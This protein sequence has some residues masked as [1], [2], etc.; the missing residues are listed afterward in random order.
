MIILDT[1]VISE[2][3]KSNSDAR[4][5]TWLDAQVADTLH[6]TTIN[7]AELLVGIETL[8]DGKRK[9]GLG[10]ALTS[11]LTNLFKD[12]ILSFDQSAAI[13]YAPII[14]KARAAG[15]TISMADGQIAAIAADKGFTIA[16]R[17][18]AP[19]H[20]AGVAVINPWKV[21]GM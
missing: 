19:F 14:A 7:L 16:T 2:P 21:G 15:H 17:D 4:V 13:A 6:L 18:A 12:R 8:P 20:A 10:S 3:M 1:N 11:L 5:L 9:Q